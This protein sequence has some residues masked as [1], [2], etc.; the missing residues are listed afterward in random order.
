[1]SKSQVKVQ[2]KQA[3]FGDT[4]HYYNKCVKK[5]EIK[6]WSLVTTSHFEAQKLSFVKKNVLKKCK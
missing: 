6:D 2:N 4:M 3:V 1:M 5:E